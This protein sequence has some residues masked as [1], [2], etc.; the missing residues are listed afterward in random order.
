MALVSFL[1]HLFFLKLSFLVI[2]DIVITCFLA[3]QLC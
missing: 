1:N 2:K 3:E